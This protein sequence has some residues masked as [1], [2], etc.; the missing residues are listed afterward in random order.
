MDNLKLIQDVTIEKGDQARID[1]SYG[2]TDLK[3][4]RNYITKFL[5]FVINKGNLDFE[6]EIAVTIESIF[7][8][9]DGY[10]SSENVSA[11]QILQELVKATN[12]FMVSEANKILIKPRP[13]TGFYALPSHEIINVGGRTRGFNKLYNSVIINNSDPFEDQDSINAHGVRVLNIS[14]YSAPSREL[15]QTYLNYYKDPKTELDME[16]RLNNRNLALKI[17]DGISF[18]IPQE[19]T[20]IQPISGNFFIIGRELNF[21]KEVIIL[22][23]RQF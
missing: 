19:N 9:A 12:S 11:L 3:L 18:S 23:L 16:I 8:P 14:T 1:R 10:Y 4:D 20:D 7:P 22:R 17:G 21:E 13:V 2:S 15:A 5:E 6:F